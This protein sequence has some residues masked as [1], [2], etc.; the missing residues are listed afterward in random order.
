MKRILS[1]LVV[2]IMIVSMFA[3][4]TAAYV[5]PFERAE[6][7]IWLM[8]LEDVEIDAKYGDAKV[9]ANPDAT[10]TNAKAL[11]LAAPVRT[12]TV[13][14]QTGKI[15]VPEFHFGT[16][17]YV[18][19]KVKWVEGDL[20]LLFKINDGTNSPLMRSFFEINLDAEDFSDGGWYTVSLHVKE[21]ERSTCSGTL[22]VKND[23]T[24]VKTQET[25]YANT[26]KYGEAEYYL[27]YNIAAPAESTATTWIIDDI[28]FYSEKEDVYSGNAFTDLI[29]FER[30]DEPLNSLNF[31][32]VAVD[33]KYSD[34]K[35]IANPD[36]T[37]DNA[38]VLQ[39]DAISRTSA[40]TTH[41]GN[42]TVPEFRF[43]EEVFV[44]FR[45]KLTAGD[46]PLTFKIN[47]GTNSPLLRRYLEVKLSAEEFEHNKWY[48]VALHV[49]DATSS[50][51]QGT[52]YAYHE[53]TGE[54][55]T[56]T[57]AADTSKWSDAE[58]YYVRYSV[59]APANNTQTTWL[60]DDVEFY[61]EK[62]IY[63]K[64][65]FFNQDFEDAT[66]IIP[67]YGNEYSYIV[68]EG[69]NSVMRFEVPETATGN[70]HLLGEANWVPSVPDYI[71]NS[72]DTAMVFS[73][74]VKKENDS[75]PLSAY[76]C[77][78]SATNRFGFMIPAQQLREDVWY[79]YVLVANGNMFYYYRKAE[80]SAEFEEVE[81]LSRLDATENGFDKVEGN[82]D[83]E[84][85]VISSAYIPG[86]RT[87]CVGFSMHNGNGTSFDVFSDLE[88]S[89]PAGSSYLID[90]VKLSE[91][92]DL[93]AD[94]KKTEEGV[95]ASFEVNENRPIV[96]ATKVMLVYYDAENRMIDVSMANVE[97]NKAEVSMSAAD[98]EA[99][100]TAKVFVWDENYIPVMSTWYITSIIN[101]A[102]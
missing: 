58:Q 23:A 86:V 81:Y 52:V 43:G 91:L 99:M 45:V 94:I 9:I 76:V 1:A 68:A 95:T 102:E 13:N 7:A 82:T 25:V 4:N 51:C 88:T 30:A 53:G 60:V 46:L 78:D 22:T 20:P 48:T 92:N 15:T 50:N 61:D 16:E 3:I 79:T 6:D 55:F 27:Y 96:T 66:N 39:V 87:K 59:S 37:E 56:K 93:R 75:Y 33:T 10:D 40:A 29:G 32:D 74:D 73:F 98:T 2:C 21:A 24:G 18:E 72:N 54:M 36:A 77:N 17:T 85:P 8:N 89:I 49:K 14:N 97:N 28:G 26:T 11:Q 31:E 64:G 57:V 90:N 44:Q 67:A 101:P 70:G 80:D 83:V 35:V 47:D 5:K 41:T 71:H 38:K 42:I 62:V 12:S 65:L 34:A 84:N 100:T 19:F 69:D 63:E